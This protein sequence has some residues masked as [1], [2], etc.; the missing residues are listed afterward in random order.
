MENFIYIL[1]VTLV[2][3]TVIDTST[4]LHTTEKEARDEFAKSL[5][6]VYDDKY[7]IR[8]LKVINGTHIEE[9]AR[10]RSDS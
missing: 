1:D 9:I 5:V 4:T 7:L 2:L 10:Y 3:G 8:L 6:E